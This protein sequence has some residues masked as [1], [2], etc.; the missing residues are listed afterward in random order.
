[1]KGEHMTGDNMTEQEVSWL[2]G[3]VD[4]MES[5]GDEKLNDWERQF[6]SDMTGRFQKY[7][8]RTMVSQK[9]WTALNKIA[10]KI[11]Y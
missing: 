8:A 1:L 4:E 7:G 6:V 9:Q 10:E 2:Q 11:G 3:F 5:R